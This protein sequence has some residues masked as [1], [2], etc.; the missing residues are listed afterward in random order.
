MSKWVS[1]AFHDVANVRGS[2]FRCPSTSSYRGY[3]FSH[4]ESLTHDGHG[5]TIVIRFPD[6]WTFRLRHKFHP[7]VEMGARDFE[8]AFRNPTADG[9]AAHD[10][11]AP[12]L[13]VVDPDPLTPVLVAPLED[14][15]HE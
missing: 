9:L 15:V 13:E 6:S 5:G 10:P 11:R 12:F 2:I 14:L 7:P 3:E 1:L 8:A 4:P